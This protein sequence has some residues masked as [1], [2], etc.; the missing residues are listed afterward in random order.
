MNIKFVDFTYFYK[1]LSGGNLIEVPIS[2][3][4]GIFYFIYV[5]LNVVIAKSYLPRGIGTFV[6]LNYYLL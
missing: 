1:V 4:D 6:N 3:I 2:Y 5:Q